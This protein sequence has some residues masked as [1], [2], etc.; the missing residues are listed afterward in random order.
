MSSEDIKN[1]EILH[2]Y[3]CFSL[4]TQ[5]LLFKTDIKTEIIDL[6]YEVYHQAGI[7]QNKKEEIPWDG[8]KSLAQEVLSIKTE[9][10]V[11]LKI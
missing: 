10:A 2:S 4:P 9:K 6:L 8:Y 3:K 5:I 11:I 1:H 7:R